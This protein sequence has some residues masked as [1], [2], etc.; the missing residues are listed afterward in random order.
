[1]ERGLERQA[2]RRRRRAA[3]LA[4]AVALAAGSGAALA[5]HTIGHYPSYYPDEILIDAVDP[6]TAAKRLA[7]NTLHAYIGAAPV[8]Q[9]RPA[10]HVRVVD[11]LGSLLVLR[12]DKDGKAGGDRCAAA[13]A[14]MAAFRASK[15]D[16]FV[17]HPYPITPYHADHIYHL[18][19]IEAAFAAAAP[20][21]PPRIE[22]KGR[23]AE[24]V[25][26]LM[27]VSGGGDAILEEV[28]VDGLIADAAIQFDGWLGPPWLKEGWFHAWR[29]L[30]EGLTGKQKAAV[31]E[32][33]S[34]VLRGD[35]G[36]L[37]EQ[38]N[39]ERRLVAALTG[40][41]RRLIVGYALRREYL[42]DAFSDGVENI[43]FDAL[44]GLNAPIFVRTAKLKD[45]PWNGSLHLGVPARAQAA[46]NPVAGFTDPAG[47]LM[48]SAL[49]DP[50]L[51]PFPYNASWV[52]NRLPFTV[53][54]AKGQS[55]GVRV[56]AD[57]V[58]PVPGGGRLAAVGG[59][60]FASAKVLYE[61]VASPHLDGSETEMAD[62]IYPFA[63]IYR[64]GAGEAR[65]P[66]LEATLAILR[67]RLV[68]L[69]PLRVESAVKAIAPGLDVVQK[70]PVL[71]V[72]LRNAPGD[73]SQVAT[74]AAPWSTVPWHLLV[75][76]E[77]AAA[78][79]YAVFSREQALKRRLPW[80]DLARDPA[81]LTKLKALIA[82]LERRKFRPEVLK[83]LVTPDDAAR[84][85][86]ALSKFADG[87]GHLL[88]TNGPYRLHSWTTDSV[89]LKAVR[90]PTY[91]LGFGSFDRYVN[92]PQGVIR[93]VRR[94]A[95]GIA[96]VADAD[97]TNKVGRYYETR[98]EPLSRNTAHGLY[99]VLVVSRYYLIGPKG[100]VV[101]AGK[102]TWT[103]DNHF[104][105]PVPATLPSGGYKV[106]VGVFLDGNALPPS[107]RIFSFQAGV[108]N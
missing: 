80:M 29:L 45:Y 64:W 15:A 108:R 30:G 96:V 40:G 88:V 66:G 31:E 60:A 42:N 5:G 7:D 39:L 103:P 55:G 76:M 95:D 74:L 11:S 23:L 44:A 48:W 84:R 49:G 32:I 65:E 9:G 93:E 62:L 107:T 52:A 53:T 51:I 14:A 85:W 75:L 73:D 26:G 46:W 22:A 47:R 104:M 99:P 56:P 34:A 21:T 12:F 54:T 70:T 100:D 72:Y 58:L 105:A 20:A 57:A 38:A 50:A 6:A 86:R 59:R 92:P 101:S 81:L 4:L 79:G 68:G 28:A 91:P 98:R 82:D 71:E 27:R 67:D 43:A 83:N 17:F 89:V 94:E 77:E 16:G 61:V 10:D 2:A 19:R 25:A 106:L 35:Y 24:A 87:N 102:M 36:G 37:A 1:M 13:R 8:F 97:I 41:C 63:F 90:E 18:D 33:Y 69:K 3:G 78:R